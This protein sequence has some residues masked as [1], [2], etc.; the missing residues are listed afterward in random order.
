MF[1]KKKGYNYCEDCGKVILNRSKRAK[2]C[3]RCYIDV[4]RFG[5]KLK[6]AKVS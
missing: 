4:K 6:K 1:N 5:S 3:A 2:R